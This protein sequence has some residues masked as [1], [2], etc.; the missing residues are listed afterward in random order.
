MERV[1]RERRSGMAIWVALIV[2]FM[3]ELL[4]YSWCRVQYRQTAYAITEASQ[5]QQRLMAVKRRLKAEE[6]CL[7]SPDRIRRIAEK[8][9]LVMPGPKQ[10]VAIP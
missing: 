3:A 7:K 2:I 1:A 5:E 10:V 6:A 4:V 9:G 8:R